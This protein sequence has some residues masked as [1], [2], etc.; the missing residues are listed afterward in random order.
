MINRNFCCAAGFAAYTRSC[1]RATKSTFHTLTRPATPHNRR[2]LHVRAL[3]LLP[4]IFFISCAFHTSVILVGRDTFLIVKQQ[5]TGL[6]G[7]RN[8]KAEFIGEGSRHCAMAGK[9]FQIVS[10]NDLPVIQRL[11]RNAL[12]E[13]YHS[14]KNGVLS[15][16]RRSLLRTARFSNAPLT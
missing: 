9:K 3:L 1:I 5:P 6:P 15:I 14:G 12:R 10:S 11:I 16:S 7:P 13:G 4:A 2:D 8:M